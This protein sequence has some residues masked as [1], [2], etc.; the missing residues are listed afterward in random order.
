[1][2]LMIYY[3]L[4]QTKNKNTH[5]EPLLGMIPSNKPPG[6]YRYRNRV[7]AVAGVIAAESDRHR[8]K[9]QLCHLLI[10]FNSYFNLSEFKLL[11]P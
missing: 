3:N 5:L 10:L 11:Q 8:F 6:M 4:N 2:L 9:A 7:C 1:M